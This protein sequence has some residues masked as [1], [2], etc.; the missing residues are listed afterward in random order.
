MEIYLWLRQQG[1]TIP[2]V[3]GP[4]DTPL[5]ARPP[6]RHLRDVKPSPIALRKEP[7]S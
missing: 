3:E 6:S 1:W 5:P 4:Y 7:V 2:L